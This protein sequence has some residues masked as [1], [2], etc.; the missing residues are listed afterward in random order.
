P[1]K[2]SSPT[3]VPSMRH[4][5]W[6]LAP[7]LGLVGALATIPAEEK[8]DSAVDDTGISWKKTVLDRAFRSEG[9][10][11]ADV[12]KD[13]KL[14]VLNGEVWYEAPTWKM[15]EI[16]PS[17]DYTEGDKNVYSHS[18]C[19]WTEDLNGDGWVDLIVI[20]FPGTPCYW[21]ENPQGKDGHWKKHEI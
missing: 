2:P 17:K 20:D 6:L 18:F 10:A 3:E 14:D 1:L 13:G 8:K 15:H 21:F 19:C 12:N 11:V 16:R 9:V 5:A 4:R 7:V